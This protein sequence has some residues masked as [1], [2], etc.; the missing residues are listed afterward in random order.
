L[1]KIV[2]KIAIIFG[3]LNEIRTNSGSD[4]SVRA[5][6]PK[7]RYSK[8][9]FDQMVIDYPDKRFTIISKKILDRTGF[10]RDHPGGARY[11]KVIASAEGTHEF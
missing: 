2:L 7:D 6:S 11:I 1:D 4:S 3:L 5:F 9:E 10:E 8:A